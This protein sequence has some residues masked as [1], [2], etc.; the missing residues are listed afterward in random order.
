MKFNYLNESLK[1]YIDKL[2]E[3][4]PCPG[5]GSASVLAVTLA[6]SLVCMVLHYTVESKFV[7]KNGQDVAKNIL[8]EALVL[9]EKIAPLIEKDS[10]IYE[11]IRILYKCVS[12]NSSSYS[13]QMDDVLKKSTALHFDIMKYCYKITEWNQLLIEHCNPNLISDVGVSS[14]LVL[15]AFKATRTNILINL[16]EIKDDKFVKNC[17]KEM[18]NISPGIEEKIYKTI[19]KKFHN[20]KTGCTSG[21]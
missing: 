5:G 13:Q 14:S 16:K 20:S 12:K 1:S 15:G 21:W 6:E 7:D 4:S 2:S 9:K 10:E 11:E 19:E 18:D 8:K 17:L 3:K